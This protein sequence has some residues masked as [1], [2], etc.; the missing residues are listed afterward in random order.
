MLYSRYPSFV[1]NS[2]LIFG[3]EGSPVS[4]ISRSKKGSGSGKARA[5][6]EPQRLCC[7]LCA[8]GLVLILN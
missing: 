4:D 2:R 5:P 1:R 3:E 7:M 8:V 6:A